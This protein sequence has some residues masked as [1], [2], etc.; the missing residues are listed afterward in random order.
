MAD[1]F[2][3]LLTPANNSG[4]VGLARTSLE[5]KVLTVA[6]AAAGLTPEERHPL[7]IHGFL[8]GRESKLATYADDADGD[9]VVE[10]AED[11]AVFGPV[12]LA[13]TQD[14]SVNNAALGANFPVA[15]EEGV[16][17]QRQTYRFDTS[18][19]TQAAIFDAPKERLAG[20]EVQFHGLFVPAMQGEG[21]G[22]EVDG[23][24]GTKEVL[25][26][27]NGILLP[28]DA[29]LAALD[30]AALAR[31]V[32]PLLGRIPPAPTDAAFA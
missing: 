13:L 16:I 24:A 30:P 3:G 1:P 4:V 12:I 8:D 23:T 20:R 21:T 15:D 17:L 22:G 7:H 14:G 28:V 26:V 31:L 9:G 32:E 5:G 25:P 11:E 19:P 29:D 10:T 2:L 18:D 6:V 27:A